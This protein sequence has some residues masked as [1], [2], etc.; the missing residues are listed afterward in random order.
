MNR[1]NESGQV[2]NPSAK[3]SLGIFIGAFFFAFQDNATLTALPWQIMNLGG[4]ELA[5][6]AVGMLSL[7]TYMVFCT[8]TGS[9]FGRL[10]AKRL[11]LTATAGSTLVIG[12]MPMMPSVGWL[13]AMIGAKGML[14][15]MFWPPIMGW[16][17][18][19]YN[20][21]ALNRRL[22][23]FNLSWSL[24]AIIGSLLGGVLFSINPWLA[25]VIPSAACFLAVIAL[26]QTPAETADAAQ[27]PELA[28][29]A[30]PAADPHQADL[31]TFQWIA[32]TGLLLGWIAFGVLRVPIA[33][34]L[35][36][37]SLGAN[38]HAVICSEINLIMLVCFLLL[39]RFTRWHYRFGLVII[40]M[41]ILI[42]VLAGVGVSK[43]SAQL[44]IFIF[45]AS[46]V[47]AFIYSS[48]LYY[49]VSG[50]G[51]RQ[52]SAA[53]HEILLALGFSI[54]SFGGG[55]LGHSL[56]VRSVY[57]VVAGVMGLAL[58]IQTVIYLRGRRS[59]KQLQPLGES[60]MNLKPEFGKIVS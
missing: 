6:G 52:G 25:F 29:I 1:N 56:G 12:C 33:S 60:E 2:K 45:L 55:A 9:R 57:F 14:M 19:G 27:T 36:E 15:S 42:G 54:G 7:G 21:S 5:V 35:K 10:G 49:S 48:H 53:L 46:P 59:A 18:A 41:M 51:H 17:S 11:A 30:Q 32:R 28:E 23:I 58:V 34:L 16:V 26:S 8:L 37:M 44:L 4:R 38:L 40:M 47:L 50:S 24:G 39:G 3:S 31:P 43:N 20:G 22:S 13:L